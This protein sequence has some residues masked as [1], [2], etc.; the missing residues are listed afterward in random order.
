MS[1]FSKEATR[2]GLAKETVR[3]TAETTPTAW[4][5]VDKSSEIN[6]RLEL[7][8]NNGLRGV[9][10][11]FPATPG[12][13]V[14]EGKVQNP[15]RVSAIA[16][17]VNMILGAPTTT[18]AEIGAAYKHS[19]TLPSGIQP[20]TYT[21]FVDRGLAIKKYNG[22]AV[23]KFG[24]KASPN[25]LISHESDIVGLTEAT[26]VIGT[27]SYADEGNPLAFNH[28]SVKVGGVANL[29]I[30]EWAFSIDSGA[31]AKRVMSGSQ[32]AA[33]IL[34]PAPLKVDGSYTIYFENET[35]RAKFLLATSNSLEFHIEGDL[36]AGA[37]KE[38]LDLHLPKVLYKAY[39]YGEADNMLAAQVT[40]EAAYD[41][42]TSKL[43]TLDVINKIATI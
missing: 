27:P 5:S 35:E 22:C 6:H 34:A 29:D 28:A 32:V 43:L 37:S 21:M 9:K 25:G 13:K 11:N 16:Y 24:L 36:I 33:D 38:T 12:I 8:E 42:A 41:L 23:K 2:W 30:K 26:G 40:F 1:P 17:F 7:L 20:P 18:V 14:T 19:F 31:F 3:L 39:P 4:F 10:A 15:L